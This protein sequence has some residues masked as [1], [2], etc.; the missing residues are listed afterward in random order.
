MLEWSYDGKYVDAS[1]PHYVPRALEKYQHPT[2]KHPVYAPHK[3]N[4]PA[5]GAKM[6]YAPEPDTFATTKSGWHKTCAIGSW[7]I[8]AFRKS[9]GINNPPNP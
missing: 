4:R 7:H 5:Y 9:S 2:P 3:W 6:Q 1:V 8:L